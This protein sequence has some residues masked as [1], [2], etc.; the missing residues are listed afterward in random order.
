MSLSV[1]KWWIAC[2]KAS[3]RRRRDA[4]RSPP[5]VLLR[6]QPA[7][8]F[9]TLRNE[10]LLGLLTL[11][12]LLGTSLTP[13]ARADVVTF[14]QFNQQTVSDQAFAYTNQGSSA[15]F[16]ALSQGIPIYMTITEGFAPSLA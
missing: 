16:A 14:A 5:A 11:A 1:M 4:T 8:R 15:T 7:W 12:T 9:A 6:C 10:L 2:R 13:I 3:T